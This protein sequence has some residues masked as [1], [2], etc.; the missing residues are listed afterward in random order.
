MPLDLKMWY[1]YTMEYYMTEKNDNTL[2][3]AGK[4]IDLGN[5]ILNEVTQ[6]QTTTVLINYFS[7]AMIKH[8]DQKQL[9]KEN[10]IMTYNFRELK[11]VLSG[12]AYFTTGAQKVN[13]IDF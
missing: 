9:A 12:T 3:F 8:H 11:Y 10:L 1:I 6:T 13:E 2:K 4:W 5:I 7:A